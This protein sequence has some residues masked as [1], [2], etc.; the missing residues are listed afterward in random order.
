MATSFYFIVLKKRE[1]W[2]GGVLT[3]SLSGSWVSVS[4][5]AVI[6]TE[7]APAQVYSVTKE[8]YTSHNRRIVL[9]RVKT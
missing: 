8:Q 3:G 9:R 7:E 5:P 4:C 2:K 6:S 1:R